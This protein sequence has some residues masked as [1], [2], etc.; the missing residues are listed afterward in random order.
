MNLA[1][2]EDCAFLQGMEWRVGSINIVGLQTTS[3]LKLAMN[4]SLKDKYNGHQLSS[5]GTVRPVFR[6]IS[7]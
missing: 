2:Y 7:L 3:E 6:L 1:Y 4:V 5:H